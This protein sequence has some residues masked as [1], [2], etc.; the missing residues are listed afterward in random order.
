MRSWKQYYTLL[1]GPL[2]NFY[3]EKRDYQQ[4]RDLQSKSLDI[5]IR[6]Y[7]HIEL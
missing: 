4:V 2:L 7:I 6:T 5:I 1:S 3:R